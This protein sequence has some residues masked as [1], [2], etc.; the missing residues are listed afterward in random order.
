MGLIFYS[1]DP[2]IRDGDPNLGGQGQLA[3]EQ[4]AIVAVATSLGVFVWR[5][6]PFAPNSVAV[7]AALST[8]VDLGFAV[9]VGLWIGPLS[10]LYLL[11]YPL[12]T[13][14]PGIIAIPILILSLAVIAESR[15]GNAAPAPG[16]APLPH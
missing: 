7:L 13:V 6:L 9:I 1:I 4:A 16:Q 3:I 5:G 15:R 2:F 14:P 11:F 8:L 10:I 12:S